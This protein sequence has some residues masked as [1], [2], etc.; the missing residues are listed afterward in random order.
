MRRWGSSTGKGAGWPTLRADPAGKVQTLLVN[1]K[2][3]SREMEPRLLAGF[4]RLKEPLEKI[5]MYS[6]TSRSV[7]LAGERHEPQAVEGEALAA[8]FQMTSPRMRN[9]VSSRPRLMKECTG[10]SG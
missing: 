3:S 9:P 1:S 5:R 8:L 7:G 10:I 4:F 6:C 2:D